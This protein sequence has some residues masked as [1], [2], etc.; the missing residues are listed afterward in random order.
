MSS[1]HIKKEFL[2]WKE[3][4]SKTHNEQWEHIEKIE[5]FTCFVHS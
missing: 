3:T 1:C 4:H 5:Q 2:N